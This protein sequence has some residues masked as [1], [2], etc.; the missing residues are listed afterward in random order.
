MC[1]LAQN[2][3][4][5]HEDTLT[6]YLKSANFKVRTHQPNKTKLL[7]DTRTQDNVG[8]KLKSMLLDP[9]ISSYKSGVLERVM[10]RAV[11]YIFLYSSNFESG[12][13]TYVSML[14]LSTGCQLM[15]ENQL[16]QAGLLQQSARFLRMHGQSS[17]KRQV[18]QTL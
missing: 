8:V 10:V 3:A 5:S 16:H 13:V 14:V 15:S 18:S 6:I 12:S 9:N 2:K 7:T 4:V 11:F 1:K 17:S